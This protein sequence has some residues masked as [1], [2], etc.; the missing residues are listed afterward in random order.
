MA[1]A[2]PLQPL[3]S[4]ADTI[5]FAQGSPSTVN[6]SIA[7]PKAPDGYYDITIEYD[8]DKKVYIKRSDAIYASKCVILDINDNNI[9]LNSLLFYVND[10]AD[11]CK[12]IEGA[13]YLN[14]VLAISKL[15]TRQTVNPDDG[16]LKNQY[17]SLIDAASKPLADGLDAVELSL[18]QLFE[19]GRTYYEA[20]GFLPEFIVDDDENNILQFNS[21][22]Y[23]DTLDAFLRY[24][25]SFINNKIINIPK[26]AFSYG[27]YSLKPSGN[28]NL[29]SSI[30]D[31]LNTKI[32]DESG[33]SIISRVSLKKAYFI[34]KDDS[35][36]TQTRFLNLL[37]Y[38][39]VNIIGHL[40][41]NYHYTYPIITRAEREA[42][43]Q[44]YLNNE[45]DSIKPQYSYF[46]LSDNLH[47]SSGN[48]TKTKLRRYVPGMGF[49]RENVSPHVDP[50]IAYMNAYIADLPHEDLEAELA[51]FL[52]EPVV[53]QP[54]NE[55]A[56]GPII[57]LP[58]LNIDMLPNLPSNIDMPPVAAVKK[59][60]RIVNRHNNMRRRTQKANNNS[61]SR[62]RRTR[63]NSS[64]RRSR[65]RS[66]VRRL[67]SSS[68]GRRSRSRSRNSPIRTNPSYFE[69][70]RSPKSLGGY[71][72]NSPPASPRTPGV[73]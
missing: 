64:E 24:R 47:G 45:I 51:G 42:I 4:L 27:R 48:T 8:G 18:L 23:L 72:N 19:K 68:S 63:R 14:L 38:G 62:G 33:N 12:E 69:S 31:T 66:P 34:A 41:S 37:N 29:I 35:V 39:T 56:N 30:I 20:Y 59:P 54:T 10:A 11:S 40:S 32:R 50:F 15:Y 28:V 73:N 13:T 22:E 3:V 5:I 43:L 55:A 58:S 52:H 25:H 36:N 71:Y 9:Y 61:G 1:A 26:S 7:N 16:S 17:I 65:S 44:V 53:P 60:R 67:N 57:R 21:Q 6:L 49:V 46:I 2:G 70:S